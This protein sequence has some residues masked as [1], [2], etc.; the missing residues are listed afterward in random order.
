MGVRAKNSCDW[1]RHVGPLRRCGGCGVQ[2]SGTRVKKL[3]R[4][5]QS[6]L[7]VA[8][9]I[10]IGCGAI[11]AQ[12]MS[13]A[14]QNDI[15][16]ISMA[17]IPD[18][19][20]PNFWILLCHRHLAAPSAFPIDCCQSRTSLEQVFSSGPPSNPSHPKTTAQQC[21]PLAGFPPSRPATKAGPK[22]PQAARLLL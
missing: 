6:P 15:V 21:F 5:R 19:Y 7:K 12:R 17:M 20:F 11:A 8:E 13:M 18:S 3:R 2:S 22:M 9:T 16:I 10:P 1:Q 14:V 4:K